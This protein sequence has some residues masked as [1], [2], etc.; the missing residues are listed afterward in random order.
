MGALSEIDIDD[1]LHKQNVKFDEGESEG[2]N[3][4]DISFGLRWSE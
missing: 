4:F 3:R 1:G 2:L